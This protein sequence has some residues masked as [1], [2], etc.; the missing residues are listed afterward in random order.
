[1]ETLSTLLFYVVCLLGCH[2]QHNSA[3]YVNAPTFPI[4]LSHP[5][6]QTIIPPVY[7]SLLFPKVPMSYYSAF[8]FDWC[9]SSRVMPS[10]EQP[11]TGYNHLSTVTM[12]SRKRQPVKGVIERNSTDMPRT[13]VLINHLASDLWGSG[14]PS[15]SPWEPAG[16]SSSLEEAVDKKVTPLMSSRLATSPNS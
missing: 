14:V 7:K 11:A 5:W 8:P 15:A 2:I 13:S 9:L 10:L 12:A 6:V 16:L 1:M 3:V 4:R